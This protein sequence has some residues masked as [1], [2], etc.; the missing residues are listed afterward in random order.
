M[1]EKNPSLPWLTSTP[2]F[3]PVQTAW[4]QES[5]A[6]GLLAAGGALTP[7]WLLHA[8]RLGIFPWFNATEPPLW[9]CP[10]PRMVLE[11]KQFRCHRSLIQTILHYQR[12][13]RLSIRCDTAFSRVI[14]ACASAPRGGKQVGTWIQPSVIQAYCEL[15]QLGYAHSFECWIDNQLV[16][17]LYCVAIGQ[18]VFGESMFSSISNASKIALA[19]LVAFCYEQGVG[20]IDCQQNTHHLAKMGGHNISR[21]QFCEHIHTASQK[22]PLIWSFNE[23]YWRHLSPKLPYDTSQ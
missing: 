19:A 9:W 1:T 21:H 11:P 18:A 16:G 22:P 23:R 14:S 5:P 6:P 13:Q 3:P 20:L 10:D 2:D 15:H 8:Y 7:Q 17:G 12:A 4:G